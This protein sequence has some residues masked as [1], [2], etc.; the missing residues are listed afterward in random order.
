MQINLYG[1]VANDPVN[2]VDPSG[3]VLMLPIFAIIGTGIAQAGGQFIGTLA[4][5]GTFNAAIE[6]AKGG[7]I[8]GSS[9]GAL[10]IGA[11]YLGIPATITGGIASG[12]F[13]IGQVIIDSTDVLGT[14]F[15]NGH[16]QFIVQCNKGRK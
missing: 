12:I 6:S 10:A 13:A 1:Y 4:V 2:F 14:D 8:S 11:L 3:K 9:A 7:F 5:G 15:A 16:K